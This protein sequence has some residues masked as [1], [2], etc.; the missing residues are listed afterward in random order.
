MTEMALLTEGFEIVWTDDKY[1]SFFEA[2]FVRCQEDMA[3][4]YRGADTSLL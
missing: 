2:L 3:A 4:L 1:Q